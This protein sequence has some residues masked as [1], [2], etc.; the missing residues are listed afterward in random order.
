MARACDDQ[1]Y[2]E[3]YL[4]YLVEYFFDEEDKSGIEESCY[5]IASNRFAVVYREGKEYMEDPFVGIKMIPHCIIIR[6]EKYSS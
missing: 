6:I 3:N 2:S 4:D 1:I 5:N